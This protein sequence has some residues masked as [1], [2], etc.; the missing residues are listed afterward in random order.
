MIKEIN[1]V[2]NYSSGLM[3]GAIL[4]FAVI[5]YWK[6]GNFRNIIWLMIGFRFFLAAA[7]SALQYLAWDQNQLSRLLL[8]LP[9]SRDIPGWLASLPIFTEFSS[10]YFAFYVWNH[11][12]SEALLSIAAAWVIYKFFKLLH[13]FNPRFFCDQEAEL[14]WLMLLV[15]GWPQ[16]VL[17]LPLVMLLTLVFSV[18][19]WVY[20]REALTTLGWP[21]IASAAALFL[22]GDQLAYWRL[23]VFKI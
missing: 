12:W 10:G 19:R 15:V 4:V 17:F 6:K 8:H 1:Q 18:A 5:L 3:M 20:G 2:I 7:K 22:F 23:L 14:G 16:A 13:R 21:L 11:F 9:L